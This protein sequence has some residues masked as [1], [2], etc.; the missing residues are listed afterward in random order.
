MPLR[1]ASGIGA[2][3]GANIGR[4]F[5]EAKA[6]YAPGGGYMEGIEAQLTRGSKKAVATGMQNLAASGLAS[7]SMAGGLGLKYEEDVA[8]PARAQATTARLSALSSLLAQEAG[9]QMQT[10]PR[11]GYQA[12]QQQMRSPTPSSQPRAATGGRAPSTT[13][14]RPQP[15]PG[16]GDPTK[17]LLKT[18]KR[19]PT[20]YQGVFFGAD[21]YR[22]QQQRRTPPVGT[23]DSY[24]SGSLGSVMQQA[25]PYDISG[26]Y[27]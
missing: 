20:G 25:D 3:A 18:P 19:E 14:P 9:V 13:R 7:T 26:R 10:A 8:T 12:P 22:Q 24:Y 17:G 23:S 16:A 4:L 15:L 11:Y 21:Y 5:E 1:L 2:A 6:L 27:F